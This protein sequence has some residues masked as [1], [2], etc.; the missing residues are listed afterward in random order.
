[1]GKK[2]YKKKKNKRERIEAGLSSLALQSKK[3]VKNLPVILDCDLSLKSHNNRDVR[4]WIAILT[5]FNHS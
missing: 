1:M 4:Y 2:I 3:E 5:F